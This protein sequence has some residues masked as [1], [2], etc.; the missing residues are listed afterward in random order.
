MYRGLHSRFGEVCSYCSWTVQ[1]GPARVLLERALRRKMLS[2]VIRIGRYWRQVVCFPC[3][4]ERQVWEQ[5]DVMQRSEM[6]LIM[7][8]YLARSLFLSLAIPEE[9]PMLGRDG[10]SAG[11]TGGRGGR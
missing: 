1:P 7:P 2:S 10:R 9:Y 8:R 6:L 11:A 4:I 5:S 3:Q